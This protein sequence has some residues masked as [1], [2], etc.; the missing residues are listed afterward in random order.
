MKGCRKI[1]LPAFLLSCF[2]WT[3]TFASLSS[4][5][6][7]SLTHQFIIG[8]A[9]VA[10][11]FDMVCGNYNNQALY[12]SFGLEQQTFKCS[13]IVIP[14]SVDYGP[15]FGRVEFAPLYDSIKA[16]VPTAPLYYFERD[17]QGRL[18]QGNNPYF[19]WYKNLGT[20]I[21]Y[22]GK[23]P[24]VEA[25]VGYN[26]WA[27]NNIFA[28]RIKNKVGL[29]DYDT[30]WD[31]DGFFSPYSY[32]LSRDLFSGVSYY[33]ASRF[34]DFQLSLLSGNNPMK[35]YSNYLQQIQGP[36]LNANTSPSFGENFYVNIG[37]IYSPENHSKIIVGA[38]QDVM[39]ST[40]VPSLNDGKRRNS[41]YAAAL[42]LDFPIRDDISIDLFAQFTRYLSGLT[43]GSI[44]NIPGNPIFR[45][46][47]QQGFFVGA[48][49]HY[50]M[51]SISYTH[52]KFDR[53]DFNVYRNWLTSQNQFGG[54]TLQNLLAMQQTSDIINFVYNINQFISIGVDYQK[55]NNPLLWVSSI[56]NNRPTYRAGANFEVVF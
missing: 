45:D 33:F 41:V 5:R 34:V 6:W 1:L 42:V 40:W 38:L 50:K 32:W 36:N 9:R 51:F 4:V 24:L 27:H 19:D 37:H 2:T 43:S 48:T 47:T 10:V 18:I 17:S 30:P 12:A 49:L 52:E 20:R 31:D 26:F 55:I 8:D 14:V 46:I 44:Q 56:L 7:D 3:T 15:F 54:L 11:G 13:K 23:V 22:L 16:V 29:P 21:Y 35:G 39:N 28:G 25:Y 53:F